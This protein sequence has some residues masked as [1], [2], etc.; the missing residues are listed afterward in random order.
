MKLK[1]LRIFF[2]ETYTI[3]K[4]FIDGVFFCDVL[5]DKVRDY[6]KDGKLDEPKVYGET[7]I[8]YGTYKMILD[9]SAHFK[10]ILPHILDVPGFEGIRIHWGNIPKNTLGCLLL[11]KN[12]EKGKVTESKVTY[13]KFID[14][15]LE[16]KQK[17]FEI[18]IL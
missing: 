4:L 6:D 11:G 1:L 13:V 12:T 16:S 5:E 14:K 15:L 18:D 9:Y 10:A 3:G 2:A 8:P 17:E 7:A